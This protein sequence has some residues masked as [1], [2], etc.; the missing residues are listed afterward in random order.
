ME[1]S[2]HPTA[3]LD[4]AVGR[5]TAQTL[6][7][8]TRE[9]VPPGSP[10]SSAALPPDTSVS[11]DSAGDADDGANSQASGA[12]GASVS[13]KFVDEHGGTWQELAVTDGYLEIEDASGRGRCRVPNKG[14]APEPGRVPGPRAAVKPRPRR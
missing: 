3:S 6:T 8:P 7:T 5:L 4:T 12:A 2:G 9:L 11:D 13:G 14:V 1:I 10:D